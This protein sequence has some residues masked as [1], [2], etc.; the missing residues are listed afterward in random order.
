M[1]IDPSKSY[2]I[3]GTKNTSEAGGAGGFQEGDDLR[4]DV[5]KTL[6]QYLSE[7]T[8]TQP[9]KNA[10][11]I[12]GNEEETPGF[13]NPGKSTPEIVLGGHDQ[14]PRFTDDVVELAKGYLETISNSNIGD[15]SNPLGEIF[16]KT[17]RAA[18]HGKKI[19]SIKGDGKS[20]IEQRVS[21]V[22]LNNRFSPGQRSP[23][24]KDGAR[25]K[26][27]G[28]TQ[29]VM[30]EYIADTGDATKAKEYEVEDLQKIAF[31]L[32]L[33]ASGRLQTDDDPN[34][35]DS[36]TILG[37][38][39][40]ALAQV[41][42]GNEKL[43]A[44]DLET[45]NAFGGDV[46][47]NNS[48]INADIREEEGPNDENFI[49]S[50]NKPG[51]SFGQTYSHLE[52][53]SPFGPYSP[54]PIA[55]LIPQFVTIATS[56]AATGLLIGLLTPGFGFK[57]ADAA[58]EEDVLMKGKSRKNVKGLAA[59]VLPDFRNALGIPIT[60]QP[61]T[62]SVLM[63]LI[64]FQVSALFG[65]AGLVSSVQRSVARDTVAFM[66]ESTGAFSGGGLLTNLNALGIL[67]DSLIN[68]KFFRF[69]CVMAAIGDKVITSGNHK[70][71]F[72][73]A[74]GESDK[75]AD[76][77]FN[78]MKKSRVS[79]TEKTLVWRAGSTP[80]SYI[81]PA[82]F[83]NS[84]KRSEE[85]GMGASLSGFLSNSSLNQ[86]LIDP[87]TIAGN[88]ATGRLP[89]E[90]VERVEEQLELEYVPFYFHDLR[91]NEIVSFHA[92]LGAISDSYASNYS[93]TTGLGRVEPA[94]IYGGTTRSIGMEFSII[95]TN[96]ESFDEMWYQINK[97]TTLMY[98]QFSRGR[99]LSDGTIKF[100]QPFSQVQTASPLIRIR[101]GDLFKSNYSKF[102][103]ARLF[104]MGQ[105]SDVYDPDGNE[106]SRE[107]AAQAQKIAEETKKIQ[108]LRTD[109][110]LWPG[111][112]VIIPSGTPLNL[113]PVV[114]GTGE[115]INNVRLKKPIKGIVVMPDL[116]PLPN[117]D[118]I[119]N[120]TTNA[121]AAGAGGDTG[122]EAPE[123]PFNIAYTINIAADDVKTL[124]KKFNSATTAPT[125]HVKVKLPELD[126][127]YVTTLARLAANVI[128]DPFA[129]PFGEEDFFK[130][131][132][133]A[134]VKSFESSRGRGL[135]GVITGMNFNWFEF[136]WS[137]E[138][139]GSK[140][141][142]ACRVS[143]TFKPIHDITPGLDAD[144]MNRAPIY[145]TGKVMN[146]MGGD[147]YGTQ[148]SD[149]LSALKTSLESGNAAPTVKEI[150][151][152]LKVE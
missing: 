114:P 61:F 7:L 113:N 65:G 29:K 44:G 70:N 120:A 5:R 141:P 50:F 126:P 79:P 144:G 34:A 109:T 97:L 91:T 9:T 89:G 60:D 15:E 129:D 80:S 93:E 49:T 38:E 77:A 147:P 117:G 146:A 98:P 140:A 42:V 134:I 2:I 148:N 135:A 123:I 128:P 25:S 68:S 37:E 35:F 27:F 133:N 55:L 26:P 16:D 11:Q 46:L 88:T 137:T 124:N 14:E 132:E 8:K 12:S 76:N 31:S 122:S 1:P 72:G 41:R 85:V 104:G 92:F 21:E 24:I 82:A 78:R 69:T 112:S 107:T 100:V 51:S 62:T 136:P 125:Y 131:S 95:A 83:Q 52:M 74:D 59:S 40:L 116:T 28:R 66:E 17:L 87:T 130:P 47:T 75:L 73:N 30:G 56:T 94:Q 43:S 57:T 19:A 63:G 54:S 33:K 64:W 36:G 138:D 39:A 145:N 110:G 67:L 86:K 121:A 143:I 118:V 23:Y 115:T 151:Q 71:F 81:L 18:K 149:E 84:L 22:L 108:A 150:A 111:A 10:Y 102:S 32:L 58:T 90:L 6:G 105:S 103:L 99:T 152:A 106:A 4:T 119:T 127:A 142:K 45:R 53:F 20:E 13:S 48:I 3:N 101:L 139:V 96:S